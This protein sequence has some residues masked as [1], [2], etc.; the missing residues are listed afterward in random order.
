VSPLR[1][2]PRKR[3]RCWSLQPSS[4]YFF[5]P[6]APLTVVPLPPGA[7]KVPAVCCA[8][9]PKSCPVDEVEKALEPKLGSE[10]LPVDTAGGDITFFDPPVPKFASIETL[11]ITAPEGLL[12]ELDVGADEAAVVV[13]LV[14]RLAARPVMAVTVLPLEEL[15]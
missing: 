5:A 3:N 8:D 9:G 15:G 6:N 14:G 10:A 4:A 12:V 13:V 2:R 7:L 1:A 11:P